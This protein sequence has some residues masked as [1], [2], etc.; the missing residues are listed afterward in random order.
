MGL[1]GPKK[2]KEEDYYFT[3]D[4]TFTSKPQEDYSP[5]AFTFPHAYSN[6]VFLMAKDWFGD[7]PVPIREALKRSKLVRA[8]DF[9]TPKGKDEID[10]LGEPSVDRSLINSYSRFDG[11][12]RISWSSSDIAKR[13]Q[14]TLEGKGVNFHEMKSPQNL[15]LDIIMGNWI[16][17]DGYSVLPIIG[18]AWKDTK[19]GKEFVYWFID[20]IARTRKTTVPPLEYPSHE[21]FYPELF[22]RIGYLSETVFPSSMIRIRDRNME[23]GVKDDRQAP[24]I[25]LHV[26]SDYY[27]LGISQGEKDLNVRYDWAPEVT[28]YGYVV[29]EH[30]PFETVDEIV[31]QLVNALPKVA[32]ILVDGFANWSFKENISF[33]S[34]L[35]TD[36]DL[37]DSGNQDIFHIGLNVPGPA[38]GALAWKSVMS[39]AKLD[40]LQRN[41]KIMNTFDNMMFHREGLFRIANQGVGP[42]SVHALNTLYY[43]II[44]QDDVTTIDV[45][46]RE[47]IEEIITYFTQYP[48]DRQD[49]NAFSNLALLQTAW[50]KHKDALHSADK[51]IALFS[52]ELQQKHVTEMSGGGQFYPI[53][54]KWELYLTKARVLVLLNKPEQAKEPLVSLIR[55]A[56]AMKFSG[57][58][59][60]DAEGLLSSL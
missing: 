32:S 7:N 17:F 40:E 37:S 56:R 25:A 45:S 51:G 44:S 35:F 10:F 39:Y 57:Q 60:I 6:F 24:K 48:F 29:D 50:G 4:V 58:E 53:I 52:S 43:R 38:Y 22:Q 1:F 12:E 34:E 41:D 49:A 46:A 54:I 14:K 16:L 13:W 28:R 30:V 15:E 36:L 2:L 59:L 3:F 42:A 5:E 20:A 27:I 8:D 33:Q 18:E 47:K 23:Y 31:I 55:E 26:Q 11:C 21:F 19:T 9:Y